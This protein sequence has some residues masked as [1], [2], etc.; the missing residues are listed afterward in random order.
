[1]KYTTLLKQAQV[2]KDIEVAYKQVFTKHLLG[3]NISSPHSTEEYYL[4][5]VFWD[6]FYALREAE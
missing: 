6:T 2:E 3:A 5:K 4:D 1:M